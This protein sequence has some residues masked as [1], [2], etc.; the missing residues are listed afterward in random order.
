MD[1]V[2]PPTDFIIRDQYIKLIK[3]SA[4]QWE[5][6]WCSGEGTRLP[7]MWPDSASYVGRVCCWFL[8]PLRG[9]FTGYS[10]LPPSTKT[11]ISKFQFDLETVERRATPWIP[12]KFLF[13]YLLFIYFINPFL[14]KSI[15]ALY[16]RDLNALFARKL[17]FIV[18]V[19]YVCTFCEY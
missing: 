14:V 4:V 18:T 12:L 9:F 7:P 13:I 6:G 2:S 15:M 3:F 5:Q 17:E 11:N 1:K 16:I 19:V 10:D 8:S